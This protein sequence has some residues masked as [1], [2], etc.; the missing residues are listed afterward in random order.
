LIVIT[1][2]TSA[3]N[4]YYS[5]L[6]RDFYTALTKKQVDVFYKCFFKFLASLLVLIPVQVS[7]RYMHTKL[8]IAWR[9]WLTEVSMR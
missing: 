1:L 5:Y 4:V 9:K 3:V 7:F 2:G 8:G 6:I